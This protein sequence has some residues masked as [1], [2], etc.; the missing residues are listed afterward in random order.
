MKF[1]S[2]GP[3]FFP[4][5]EDANR[6]RIDCGLPPSDL[7]TITI[8]NR[9]EICAFLN[10]LVNHNIQGRQTYTAPVDP[11]AIPDY[12]PKFLHPKS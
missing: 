8:T 7:H 2:V 10:G 9:D 4:F 12:V 6:H 1:Y 3:C 5:K 11:E